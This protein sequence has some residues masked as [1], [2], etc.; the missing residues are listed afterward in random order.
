VVPPISAMIHQSCAQG[1]DA[2]YSNL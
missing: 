2:A 1:C